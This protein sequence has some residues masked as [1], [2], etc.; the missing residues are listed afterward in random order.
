MSIE[1]VTLSLRVSIFQILMQKAHM[2]GHVLSQFY[3]IFKD[4]CKI[5]NGTQ[6]DI[7]HSRS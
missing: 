6:Q 5:G 3:D 2:I 7:H 1:N 4:R